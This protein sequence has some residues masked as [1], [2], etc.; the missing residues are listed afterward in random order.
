MAC[1]PKKLVF[2]YLFTLVNVIKSLLKIINLINHYFIIGPHSINVS[3]FFIF[4]GWSILNFV[5]EKKKKLGCYKIIEI[6][7]KHFNDNQ[8]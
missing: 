3:L 1:R 5:E 8:K 6:K 2:L 7:C 4:S